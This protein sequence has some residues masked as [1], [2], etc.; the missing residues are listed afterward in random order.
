MPED[1]FDAFENNIKVAERRVGGT[2]KFFGRLLSRPF[3]Y[4]WDKIKGIFDDE[5]EAENDKVF[6]RKLPI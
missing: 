2:F 6:F 3:R 5:K 1:M 4:I